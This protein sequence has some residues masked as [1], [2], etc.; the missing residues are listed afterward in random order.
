[1]ATWADFEVQAPDLA[2]RAQAVLERHKHH[3]LATLRADGSPRVSGTEAP[4]GGGQLWFGCMP[5]S[6]KGRDLLRDPRFALHGAPL[7][8]ELTE[9][10]DARIAGRAIEVSDPDELAAFWRASGHA[11]SSEGGSSMEALVFRC[12]I[13]DASL[14]TVEGD[15]L[16]IDSWRAGHPPRQV[17]RK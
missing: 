17:R 9:F 11:D 12:D 1:M 7:D 14:V 13:E 8:L 16:V 6:M 3:V 10:G 5:N 2:R 15:E 4:I